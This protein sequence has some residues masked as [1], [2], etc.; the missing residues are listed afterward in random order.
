MDVIR[1]IELAALNGH[2][3]ILVA[4][5]YFTKWVEAASY[6][7]VN[8]KVVA[9]FVRDH[10]ICR[11][12]VPESIITG[13]GANLN[14]DLMKATCETFKIKHRNS[15][16]YRPQM[17]GAMEA[18]PSALLGYRTTVRM[19]TGATPYLLL[20]GIEVVIPAKVEISS[21]RII[22]EA[23]LSDVDWARSRYEQLALIVGKRMNAVCHGQLYKNRMAKAFNKKPID[24]QGDLKKA[25]SQGAK[26]K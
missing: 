20:Y 19:Q 5:D 1:P 15:T 16:A 13:N 7:A 22:Q 14:N 6:K 9:D 4:I 25:A 10:I 8:K 3:F 12:G 11:F 26:A 24:P 18:L 17:N 23:E 2:K 21:L